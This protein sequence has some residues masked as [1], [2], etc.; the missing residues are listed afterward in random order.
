MEKHIR[1]ELDHGRGLANI[2]QRIKGSIIVCL[3]ERADGM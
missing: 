1:Q 2:P 3:L